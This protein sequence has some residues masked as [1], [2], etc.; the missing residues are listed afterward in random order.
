MGNVFNDYID[1]YLTI[2]NSGDS[3]L[4]GKCIKS[5]NFNDL[6]EFKVEVMIVY[7]IY[8]HSIIVRL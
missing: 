8:V 2:C 5:W 6:Y 7:S 3:V 1:M 4:I